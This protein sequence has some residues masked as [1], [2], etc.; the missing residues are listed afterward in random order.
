MEADEGRR[1]DREYGTIARLVRTAAARHGDR[2][3]IVDADEVVSFTQLAGRVT[4][5]TRALLA[6]GIA[7]GDR[8]AIWAPNGWR[9]IVTALAVHSAG[10]VLVPIN[11]RFK[12]EEA[13]Y[14]LGKSGARALFATT[15]FLGVD[16]LAMLG[17]AGV[18]LPAL[19]TRVVISGSAPECALSWSAFLAR[20]AEVPESAAEAR[21]LEVAPDD[22]C[23]IMFTS[24]TTGRPKG[25][26]STHA[27][28]L[29][30]FRDWSDIV[31]LR[32]GDRYL[33]VLPFFHS[34]GYKAGWMA[35]L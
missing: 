4:D 10:A 21:A 8:V 17:K 35:C 7:R 15:D 12:G 23:D 24:G 34:F 5:A 31:G 6:L 33:V 3:A 19:E 1:G 11:T 18:A 32:S 27:Q 20:G 2:P 25:A 9:W 22:V 16:A 29:R 28:T 30:A 26:M 13:G 14:V